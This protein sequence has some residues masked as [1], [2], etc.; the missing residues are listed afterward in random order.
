MSLCL[1]NN[2]EIFAKLAAVLMTRP[3]DIKEF[4]KHELHFFA[5]AISDNGNLNL[6]TA[7]ANLFHEIIGKCACPAYEFFIEYD[8]HIIDGAYLVH[9]NVPKQ[10]ATFLSY[11]QQ[12]H[13][14]V[15]MWHTLV[16]R[17]DIVFDVYK[18]DSLKAATRE[19]RG[20]GI[21]RRVVGEN[22]VPGNWTQFLRDERNK[23]E[24]FSFLANYLTTQEYQSRNTLYVTDGDKVLSNKPNVSMS[25]C[26]HE[27]AD[28]RLI[29]HLQEILSQGFVNISVMSVDTDVFII[30][31][32]M[33]H[34]LQASYVFT[35]IN[36]DRRHLKDAKSVG[37]KAV[38]ERLGQTLCQ[39]IP[40][41]HA[42]TGC[43]TTSAFKGIGKKKG[44]EILKTYEPAIATFGSFFQDPFQNI[45]IESESFKIIQRFVILM[46]SKVSEYTEVDVARREFFFS[47]KHPNPEN[48]PP[49]ENAL[50]HH[51]KRAIY[52]TGVWSRSLEAIANLP[53]PSQ[54]GWKRS[55]ID[56]NIPWE[57]VWF[58]NGEVTKVC[59]QIMLHCS[60]KAAAGCTQCTCT[61]ADLKCTIICNCNCHKIAFDD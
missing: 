3:I 11:A 24:L 50:F 51:T 61:K 23:E 4:F 21:R 47:K 56:P 8:A 27:E 19:K 53:S 44:Y 17:V 1:Q 39:A 33:F 6:P 5:P 28:T 7:K 42:L 43:D 12:L 37:I 48:I 45:N 55:D 35:D 30:I 16:L 32:A 40:F 20:K 26:N 52:Q 22:K 9:F 36:F 2:A 13:N 46:Y 29:L 59:A 18:D 14:Y 54:F 60:C 31:L 41:L 49:T 58:T 10:D 25:S 57:P 34:K 38:A 15:K